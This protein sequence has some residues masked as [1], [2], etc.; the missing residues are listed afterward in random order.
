M[1]N[2]QTREHELP[3]YQESEGKERNRSIAGLIKWEDVQQIKSLKKNKENTLNKEPWYTLS[4]T[5]QRVYVT[6]VIK[7]GDYVRW[8]TG[9]R[10]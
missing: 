7:S 9:V 5:S 1:S 4:T 6:D 8:G 3:I 2:N 10:G